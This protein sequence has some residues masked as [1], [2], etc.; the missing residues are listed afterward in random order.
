MAISAVLA[1]TAASPLL[2]LVFHLL[3]SEWGFEIVKGVGRSPSEMEIPVV[4]SEMHG[5]RSPGGPGSTK[6]SRCDQ[7]R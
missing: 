6:C 7:W 2:E 4:L 3:D 5:R 1:R